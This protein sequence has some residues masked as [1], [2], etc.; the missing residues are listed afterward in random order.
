MCCEGGFLAGFL[1]YAIGSGLIQVSYT[2]GPASIL[3]SLQS[4]TLAAN[5]ILAPLFLGEVLNRYDMAITFWI[6]VGCNISLSLSLSFFLLS[7][8]IDMFD[9]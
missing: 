4:L 7:L 9:E 1:V 2:L 6:F 5:S 8:G 3:G